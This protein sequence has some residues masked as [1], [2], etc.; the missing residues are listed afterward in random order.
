MVSD[1]LVCEGISSL[2]FLCVYRYEN[3][4]SNI[5]QEEGGKG[6]S[7]M[8]SNVILM[9]CHTQCV[10]GAAQKSRIVGSHFI[11]Y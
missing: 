10:Q 8:D 2:E 1:Y 7:W 4:R 9:H 5:K 11:Y 6:A 3:I